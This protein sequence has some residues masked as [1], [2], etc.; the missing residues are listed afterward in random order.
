MLTVRS[1]IWAWD[2]IQEN[3]YM[4]VMCIHVSEYHFVFTTFHLAFSLCLEKR[5]PSNRQ[6][7]TIHP[8]TSIII[9]VHAWTY[10]L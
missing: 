8:L 10:A 4:Y 6:S 7:A 3:E 1:I 9:E 2:E 5:R